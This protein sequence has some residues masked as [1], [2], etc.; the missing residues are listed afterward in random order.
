[1]LKISAPD[2]AILRKKLSDPSTQRKTTNT[3]FRA[4]QKS[5]RDVQKTASKQHRYQNRTG[6]LTRSIQSHVEI[7]KD[8]IFGV[9]GLSP[10][11]GSL[12][13]DSMFGVVYGRRIH[14]GFGSWSPDQFVFNAFKDQK[15][16]IQNYIKQAV[17]QIVGDLN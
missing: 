4:V 13:I 7:K 16:T 11:S 10:Y 1:M 14:E 6:N 2:L 17:Q 12:H 15:S 9:T 5:V 8:G 3:L